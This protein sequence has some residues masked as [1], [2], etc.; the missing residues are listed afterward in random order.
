[1]ADQYIAR[2]FKSTQFLAIHLRRLEDECK[3]ALASRTD[4]LTLR[5]V[6]DY[7][8][9]DATMLR[10]QMSENNIDMHMPIH[11]S[12]DGQLPEIDKQLVHYLNASTY[13]PSLELD[14][15]QNLLVEI[16]IMRKST[17]FVGHLWSTMSLN[18]AFAREADGRDRKTNL[19]PGYART[20][21]LPGY[22]D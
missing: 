6:Y 21:W 9:I 8:D 22:T 11:L 2:R 16:D 10:R 1:M 5:E 20:R 12:T 3:T 18:I 17:F 19:L 14:E 13:I 4:A 7:C 15:K